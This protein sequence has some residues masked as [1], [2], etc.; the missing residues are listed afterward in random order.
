MVYHQFRKLSPSVSLKVDAQLTFRS[1]NWRL[2]L[3]YTLVRV[4]SRS[5]LNMI[6]FELSFSMYCTIPSFVAENC[7]GRSVFS[8]VSLE[9]ILLLSLMNFLVCCSRVVSGLLL[10]L[11]ALIYF[12]SSS[13]RPCA[14]TALCSS[15]FSCSPRTPYSNSITLEQ[16]RVCSSCES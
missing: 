5:T 15:A 12:L 16:I 8:D 10:S 3:T 13:L 9:R 14:R 4:A 6:S 7:L 1:S 2:I 11:R